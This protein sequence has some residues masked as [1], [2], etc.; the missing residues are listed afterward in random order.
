MAMPGP[1]GQAASAE[2]SGLL[3]PHS[4]DYLPKLQACFCGRGLPGVCVGRR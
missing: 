3:R 2:A 4:R 1:G